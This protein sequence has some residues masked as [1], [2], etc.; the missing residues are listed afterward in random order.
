MP[1]PRARGFLPTNVAG[2]WPFLSPALEPSF[3]FT[4]HVWVSQIHLPAM[5]SL[6]GACP[7]VT[8]E[9]HKPC[10]LI[11]PKWDAW[12]PPLE[13]LRTAPRGC[14]RKRKIRRKLSAWEE[15]VAWTFRQTLL[16][17]H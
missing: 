9:Q 12:G 16:E 4:L 7:Q 17:R 5:T 11:V 14:K 10:L 3:S 8:H 2:T 1:V 6:P 13:W 15:P